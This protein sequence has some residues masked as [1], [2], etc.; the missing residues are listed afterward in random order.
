MRAVFAPPDYL[1]YVRDNNLFA[2][3]FDPRARRVSGVPTLIAGNVV[4]P[5]VRGGGVISASANGLVA[6]GGEVAGSRLVWFDRSGQA[7][8]ALTAPI[9]LHDFAASRDSS[10]LYGSAVGVWA[11]DVERDVPT[12]LVGDARTP[13]PSPTVASSPTCRRGRQE[14]RTSTCVR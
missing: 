7:A 1:L 13:E 11:V 5:T 6:L 3:S 12:R 2:Q 8:R 10:Q 14:S 9:E 4:K